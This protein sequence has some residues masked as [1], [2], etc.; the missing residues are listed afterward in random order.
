M[1]AS[2]TNSGTAT[3]IVG[4]PSTAVP[5]VEANCGP[6]QV[7]MGPLDEARGTISFHLDRLVLDVAAPVGL[8]SPLSTLMCSADAALSQ[9]A[10]A[11]SSQAASPFFTSAAGIAT[12]TAGIATTA[13][14]AATPLQT[15][16]AALNQM[17]AAF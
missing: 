4:T 17:L 10:S 9:A 15:F 12:P 16:V 14:T 6:M 3:T 5:G 2:G 8:A 1:S 13:T 7:E 11:G